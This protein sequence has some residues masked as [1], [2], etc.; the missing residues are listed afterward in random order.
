MCVLKCTLRGNTIYADLDFNGT[1]Q[2]LELAAGELDGLTTNVTISVYN[3]GTLEEEEGFVLLIGVFEEDLDQNDR[4]FVT[5]LEP[6]V[7]V[8]LLDS[9]KVLHTHV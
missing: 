9:G 8:Q 1:T 3:D 2:T 6:V 7:L 5:V 4:G